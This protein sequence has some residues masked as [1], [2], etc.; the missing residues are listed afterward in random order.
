MRLVKLVTQDRLALQDLEEI[1]VPLVARVTQELLDQGV[2][3]VQLDQL[4]QV[5]QLELL[6]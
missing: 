2:T 6:V 4:A 1:L 5:V 3:Q